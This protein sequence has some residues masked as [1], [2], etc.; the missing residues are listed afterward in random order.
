MSVFLGLDCGGSSCR[1][2]A[3]DDTDTTLFQGQSGA[4]N[5]ASTPPH[6]LRMHLQKALEGCPQPDA[7][8][9]CFAGLLTEADR[10]RALA[11]MRSFFPDASLRAEPDYL[12]AYYASEVSID[13]CVISGTGSLVCSVRDGKPSKSGGRGYILGDAGSAYRHGREALGHY[14]N[15]PDGA[16]DRMRAAIRQVFESES[17]SEIVRRLYQSATPA[18]VL[19]KLAKPLGQDARAGEAYARQILERN[20]GELAEIVGRHVETHLADVHRVRIGAAGGLWQASSDYIA[21]FQQALC[22]RLGE[23][24]FELLIVRRPPVLGAV[25][26]AKEISH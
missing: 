16:T 1:S 10:E 18:S 8:A 25:A 11:L 17:E 24:R 22:S 26:M 9:A 12:A 6:K 3:V 14:L 13:V 4:A 21:T 23:E 2:L 5:L 19:A 7:V 15:F 20:L